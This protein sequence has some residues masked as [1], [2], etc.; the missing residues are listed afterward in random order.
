MLSFLTTLI[1]G[2]FTHIKL[3][4]G[5]MCTQDSLWSGMSY[6][7]PGLWEYSLGRWGISLAEL[8]SNYLMIPSIATILCIILLSISSVFIIDLF[9]FKNKLSII[10]TSILIAVSPF[11]TITFYYV[12]TSVAYIFAFLLGILSVWFLYNFKYRKIG[13]CIS[14]VLVAFTMGMYQSYIGTI[15]G[16]VVTLTV[17][18]LLK[19]NYSIKEVIINLF[20]AVVIVLIGAIIYY[21]ITISVLNI[22]NIPMSEYGGANTISLVTIIKNLNKSFIDAYY[23]FNNL[24]MNNEI[25][26]NSRYK[27]NI[28]SKIVLILLAITCIIR[29]IRLETNRKDKIFKAFLA[30]ILILLIPVAFN[31]I[32]ILVGRSNIYAL[33]GAQA[34]LIFPFII[35]VTEEIL[36]VNIIY[37]FNYIVLSIFALTYF[38]QANVSYTVLELSYN[39][40]LN[41]ISKVLIEVEMLEEYTPGQKIMFAGIIDE[42]NYKRP[43]NLYNFS[44]GFPA[45]NAVFHGDYQGQ[46]ATWQRI[47]ELYYGLSIP[48]PSEEQYK[49]I[50]ESE[51]FSNMQEYPNRNSIKNIEDVIVIKFKSVPAM[52]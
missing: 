2:F 30:M 44:Y 32:D 24:F 47:I 15:T 18:F 25:L 46:I 51:E 1:I 37:F 4:V 27:R 16:L 20:K 19:Y 34:I 12:H 26:V 38:L 31:F 42:N 6:C 45:N 5:L 11:F 36:D 21:V 52:P 48:R 10:I 13:F 29:V 40:A 22:N 41:I 35:A 8:L 28:L 7:K 49:R 50:V 17:L 14:S 33:T 23:D 39:Q 9:K 43:S 3:I